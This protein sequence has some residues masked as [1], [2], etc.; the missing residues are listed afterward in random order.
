[1]KVLFVHAIVE[2]D[3]GHDMLRALDSLGYETEEYSVIQ[4]RPSFLEDEEIGTLEVYI[5]EHQ[6]QLAISIHFVMNAAMA[7]YKTGIKYCAV[8]WDA[9]FVEIYNPMSK[10]NNVWI[11]T[12]DK[13]DRNRFLEYGMRHVL[14]QPL[15]VSRE[16]AAEWDQE[17]QTVLQGKY[18]YDISFIGSLYEKN[19]Y[20]RYLDKIPIDMRYYFN[21]IFEEAAFKWDGVNRVYGKTGPEII[22]YIKRVS[23][24]FQ[25]PNKQDIPDV[26]YF[27]ALALIRKIANIERVAVLN[28]LAEQHS[29]TVYTPDRKTAE[30]KLRNVRI[31]PPVEYG[32][33][34]ALAYAG[35]RINLHIALKGIEGGTS[36]RVMDIMSAGGFVMSSYCAET[37]ELYEEDK[38]IVMFRD[39]EELLYKTDYYLKHDEERRKIAQAGYARVMRSYTYEVRMRMLMEWLEGNG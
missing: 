23:P 38:Q 8:L 24:D 30:E 12:F 34:T 39:P 1:M 37:A 22:E 15:A 6:I 13:L 14:Y 26:Q 5:R 21:S 17:I 10:L 35:S 3:A 28:L 7:A 36:L 4:L 25:I 31:G 27:E 16:K 19:A 9:P 2:Q 11:S 29:V 32:K 18:M 20:D 33:A